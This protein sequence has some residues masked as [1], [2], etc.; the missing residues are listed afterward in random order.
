M[1][2]VSLKAKILESFQK[3]SRAVIQPVLF[4]AIMGTVLAVAVILKMDFMPSGIQ[5][6]GT[7]LKTMMDT[8]LGNLS[9]IFCV[10]LSA[11][12]AKQKKVDAAIIGIIVYLFFLAA[13]NAWLV[14]QDMITVPGDAGLYGTGQAMVLGYQ[15]VDMNVFLG[16]L[17][18]CITG[19]VHNK[20]SHVEFNDVFRMYGGS[21]LTFLIMIPVVMV[22]SVVLCYVWPVVSGWITSLTF[23]IEGS[24]TFGVFNY[25][26]WNMWLIP[27]GL[28]HLLWMPF[29]YT[30]I[31]GVLEID[32][33]VITGAMSIWYSQ[34][35]N[36]DSLTSIHES[37]RFLYMGMAKMFGSIGVTLALIKTAKPQNK[38]AVK[39]MLLPGL[40]VAVMTGIIEPLHFTYLFAAPILWVVYGAV[41][42]LTDSILY[43]LN[44][45]AAVNNG[46]ID[47]LVQNAV[48]D[49]GLTKIWLVA[50]VGI[51]M[52]AVMYYSFVFVIVKFNLKTPGREDD[53]IDDDIAKT[54]T[55]TS[56]TNQD[57]EYIISG[58]GGNDNIISVG[59]CFTRLRVQIKDQSLVSKDV[60]SKCQCSGVVVNGTNVQ[61]IVGMKVES[62]KVQVC[63]KLGLDT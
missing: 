48:I 4:M 2:K 59:N 54:N 47:A 33:Q 46:I 32:G 5:F 36:A 43:L 9:V 57:V 27:T 21:R 24:G 15:V 42:G 52:I 41:A 8:M 3:F 39:G 6:L 13:N 44:C 56:F 53:S 60:I 7:F 31:G 38:A 30:P 25:T 62:L 12:L 1:E 37:V 49:P 58:L 18:G 29:Y 61:V 28:H 17:L 11:A 20:F 55:I 63:N 10:G 40:L 22:L 45:G 14:S 35:S 19:F 50:I 34:M 23:F 26:A 16:M 51:G